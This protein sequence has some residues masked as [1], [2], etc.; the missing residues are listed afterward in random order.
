MSRVVAPEGP[1]GAPAEIE[2]RVLRVEDLQVHFPVFQRTVLRRPTGSVKAVD[3][4]SFELYRGE[5]FGLVGESG[6]G[7]ST[8][9]FAVLRKVE[10]TRGRILFEGGDITRHG[11][12]RMRP[13]RS[14]MQMVHQDPYGSLNPRMTVRDIVSE[15]LEVHRFAGG[16]TARR[17]R[18]DELL[19]LVGLLPDMAERYPHEFSGGQRQ[20]IGIAR[21]I[22]L[23][24][25]LMVCDEPVSALDVSIQAQIVNV[26]T[27]LQA[28]LGMAHLFISHNLAVV[29]HVCHRVAVMYLDKISEIADREGLHAAP[30][31]P[32]MQVLL[33]AVPAAD[34]EV[35][36]R[37]LRSSLRARSRVR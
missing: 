10:P 29:Q 11:P 36:R 12:R 32:D 34:P 14:R 25:S 15:P 7:K 6:C 5:T 26:L 23:S 31:H 27:D 1:Q 3:G 37:G 16:R 30:L 8:I 13:L 33:S 2:T 9:G 19:A 4:V 17:E 35:E 22:A 24:P 18:V 28:R 21:A 20:R